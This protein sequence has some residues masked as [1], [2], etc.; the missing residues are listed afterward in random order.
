MAT[1]KGIAIGASRREH[2]SGSQV[3]TVRRM[4]QIRTRRVGKVHRCT[5]AQW[6]IFLMEKGCGS[7]SKHNCGAGVIPCLTSSITSNHNC[8]HPASILVLIMLQ[9]RV[10]AISTCDSSKV[11]SLECCNCCIHHACM[12][13][14]IVDTKPCMDLNH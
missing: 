7:R 6:I 5:W 13:L 1:A 8:M 12:G 14:C 11:L 2:A 3:S 4:G 9:T 10:L